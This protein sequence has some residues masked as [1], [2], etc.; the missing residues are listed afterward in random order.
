MDF[1]WLSNVL[2]LKFDES[3]TT[4]SLAPHLLSQWVVVA[5]RGEVLFV[6]DI[7]VCVGGGAYWWVSGSGYRFDGS[8]DSWLLGVPW[9]FLFDLDGSWKWTFSSLFD[10]AYGAITHTRVPVI[11]HLEH[12]WRKYLLVT[13]SRTAI[14]L[15]VPTLSDIANMPVDFP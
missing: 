2:F 1:T 10:I 15:T 4:L 14:S 11:H 9:G 13:G 5:R 8:F 6:V 12:L 3:V 7:C